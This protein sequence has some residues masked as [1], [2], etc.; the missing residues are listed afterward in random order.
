MTNKQQFYHHFWYFDLQI[1]EDPTDSKTVPERVK[2]MCPQA[3]SFILHGNVRYVFDQHEEYLGYFVDDDLFNP[4]QRYN[5]MQESS[6]PKNSMMDEQF[7]AQ[8]N[9]QIKVHEGLYFDPINN[10]Y[11]YI[12]FTEWCQFTEKFKHGMLLTKENG[13]TL[14]AY[15][16]DILTWK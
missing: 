9:L 14:L 1:T 15:P 5:R 12:N 10:T 3:T 13:K 2:E 4:Y 16:E 8:P 11:V 7:L 6:Q